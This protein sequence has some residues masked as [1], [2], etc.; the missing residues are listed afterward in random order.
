MT[1]SFPTNVGNSVPEQI[2]SISFPLSGS[3][4][5]EGLEHDSITDQITALLYAVNTWI[6][7]HEIDQKI[8]FLSEHNSAECSVWGKEYKNTL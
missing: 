8:E 4:W 7:A 3:D 2:K 6:S 1:P 5:S